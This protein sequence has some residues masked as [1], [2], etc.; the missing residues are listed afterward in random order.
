MDPCLFLK[1][2]MIC[3]VHVD[4]TILA[5]LNAQAIQDKI[6]GLGVSNEEHLH[7]FELRDED[8]VGDFLSI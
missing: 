2:D 4:D 5:G 8:Q 7:Q 3:V 1:R 6:K